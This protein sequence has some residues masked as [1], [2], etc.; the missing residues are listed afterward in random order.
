MYGCIVVRLL[1]VSYH[2]SGY[3]LGVIRKNVFSCFPMQV[4]MEVKDH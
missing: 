1:M 4:F 2:L 3:D